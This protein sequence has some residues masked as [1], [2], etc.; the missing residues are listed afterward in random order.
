M[1]LVISSQSMSMLQVSM[2]WLDGGIV[3]TCQ[4]H[5]FL[6]TKI[7]IFD[8]KLKYSLQIIHEAVFNSSFSSQ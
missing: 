5:L 7:V 3:W 1:M 2:D 4:E 6:T 8:S